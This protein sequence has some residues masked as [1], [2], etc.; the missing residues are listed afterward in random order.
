M[1]IH[2]RIILPT[3]AAATIALFVLGCKG[4]G[5]AA[6]APK[7]PGISDPLLVSQKLGNS[8]FSNPSPGDNK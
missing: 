6:N 1:K 2:M 3:F 8:P 7:D 5:V 4:T